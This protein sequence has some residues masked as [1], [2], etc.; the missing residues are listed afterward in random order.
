MFSRSRDLNGSLLSFAATFQ[1]T[2]LADDDVDSNL[3]T[4]EVSASAQDQEPNF[5]MRREISVEFAG[6]TN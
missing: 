2:R 1:R 3:K 5:K 4:T 6:V